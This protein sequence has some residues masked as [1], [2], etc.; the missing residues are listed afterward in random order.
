[1]DFLVIASVSQ[2][3]MLTFILLEGN[4]CIT[5]LISGNDNR[6]APDD[7][8]THPCGRVHPLRCLL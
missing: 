3:I 2:P 6:P 4:K 5:N 1:M 8:M 7:F